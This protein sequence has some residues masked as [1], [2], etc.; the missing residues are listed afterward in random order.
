MPF[1][2][3]KSSINSSV[4]KLEIQAQIKKEKLVEFNQTKLTFL[5]DIKDS[6]GYMGY[7]EHPGL[8]FELCLNW[9][10]RSSLD[11]FL[12]CEIY[13][14]FHGALITLGRLDSVKIMSEP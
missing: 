7:S 1:G 4:E 14:A 3:N 12:A 9:D 6:D 2:N 5:E 11:A 10:K 13:R 8:N